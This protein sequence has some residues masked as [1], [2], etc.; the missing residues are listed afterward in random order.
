MIGRVDADFDGQPL[1]QQMLGIGAWINRDAHGNALHD[2]REVA[3]RVIGR[4]Q[5]EGG[6]GRRRKA[7]DPTF[8]YTMRKRIDLDVY[9]LANTDVRNLRLFEVR[10]NPQMR[11]IGKCHE[12]LSDGDLVADV[13]RLLADDAVHRRGD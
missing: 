7:C 10:V 3:A 13:D 4:D 6:A 11:L 12:W 9:W 2:L 8:K 5:G 1:A